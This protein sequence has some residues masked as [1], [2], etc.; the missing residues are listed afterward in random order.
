M[1]CKGRQHRNPLRPEHRAGP[2]GGRDHVHEVAIA[3]ALTLVIVVL[4]APSLPEVAHWR[5]FGRELL[6][7]EPAPREALE[8][9]LADLLVAELDVNVAEEVLAQVLDH[10]HLHDGTVLHHLCV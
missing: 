7:C 4:P 6:A 2:P 3:A 1:T 10:H 9:A 5:V 8:S